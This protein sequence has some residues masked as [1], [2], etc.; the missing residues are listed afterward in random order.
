[1]YGRVLVLPDGGVHAA[2]DRIL[3]HPTLGA[4]E[5]R[6]ANDKMPVGQTTGTASLANNT[7]STTSEATLKITSLK[8]G[9]LPIQSVTAAKLYSR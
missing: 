5:V 9:G 7:V 3:D 1:M 4:P 6:A 8:V 2:A